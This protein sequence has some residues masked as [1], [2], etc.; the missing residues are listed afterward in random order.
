[1]NQYKITSADFVIPGE[2]LDPDAIIDHGQLS[3]EVPQS[4][5]AA[6][7]KSQISLRQ[8]TSGESIEIH[9][10]ILKEQVNGRE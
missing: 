9:T 6:F 1:M 8:E 4:K 10:S 2:S 5:L 7:L 3:A